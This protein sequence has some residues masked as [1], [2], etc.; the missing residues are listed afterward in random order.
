MN[1]KVHWMDCKGST[2]KKV[3]LRITSKL[4]KLPEVKDLS[5]ADWENHQRICV[6][7]HTDVE[8]D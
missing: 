4:R 3:F 2:R 5:E 8:G 1:G 7:Y 6:I